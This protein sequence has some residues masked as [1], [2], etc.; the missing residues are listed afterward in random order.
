LESR[1]SLSGAAPPPVDDVAMPAVKRQVFGV[2]TG[3][4]PFAR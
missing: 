2:A 4:V 3:A 1:S